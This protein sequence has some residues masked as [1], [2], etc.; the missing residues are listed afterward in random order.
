MK[1]VILALVVFIASSAF[2]NEQPHHIISIGTDGFGWSGLA[3]QLKWDEE[4][5]G[6][7]NHEVSEGSFRLNYNYVLDNRVM[8][9][10]E[11]SSDSR[12]SE[13]KAVNGDKTTDDT[14]KT[15]VGVSVGYNFNQD[16]NRSW[17][18]KGTLGSGKYNNETDSPIVETKLEY[19]YSFVSLSAGKRISLESWGL[20]NFSYNP[21]IALKSAQIS[22]DAK[23][24][25][26]DS[27]TEAKFDILKFDILF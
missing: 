11:L 19:S 2:A 16:L 5:S 18:V 15:E 8:L 13:I 14:T 10:A 25:G 12:K 6:I 3:Q 26:L 1:K 23:D 4:E 21:S 17:W 27:A 7:K 20:K 24:D 22:G 9:G